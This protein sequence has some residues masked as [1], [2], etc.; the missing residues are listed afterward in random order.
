MD[1]SALS[2]PTDIHGQNEGLVIKLD[3]YWP[4]AFD[5]F[6]DPENP[7]LLFLYAKEFA[8]NIYCR[9]CDRTRLYFIRRPI[10]LVPMMKYRSA[11]RTKVVPFSDHEEALKEFAE[12]HAEDERYFISVNQFLRPKCCDQ[13]F[14]AI[15]AICTEEFKFSNLY[16][17]FYHC[18]KIVVYLNLDPKSEA[19]IPLQLDRSF[20]SVL[21]K[22]Y[23]NAFWNFSKS[24]NLTDTLDLPQAIF[25]QEFKLELRDYQASSISWMK[26]IE[27]VEDCAQNTINHNVSDWS[28]ELPHLKIKLGHTGYYA[29]SR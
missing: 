10:E 9:F 6:K 21:K 16:R 14:S 22:S 23:L 1:L 17:Y 4:H 25:S 26:L 28:N 18:N 24:F 20:A 15:A 19:M 13:D 5:N 8:A 27:A 12:S 11:T 2:K 29:G 3:K 7:E